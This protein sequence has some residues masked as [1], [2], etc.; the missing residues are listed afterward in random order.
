MSSRSI[1]R[2]TVTALLFLVVL[3]SSGV[4]QITHA[5]TFCYT[6]TLRTIGAGIL[7]VPTF[8]A[9]L[10]GVNT[11]VCE[12]FEASGGL[13]AKQICEKE[14]GVCETPEEANRSFFQR[15]IDEIVGFILTILLN[16]PLQLLALVGTGFDIILNLTITDFS[17]TYSTHLA[18]GIETVWKGFRDVANIVMIGMF[19]FVAFAVILNIGKYGLK[20]LGVR[21]LIVAVLINF[22]LFFTKA[23]IDVS[24]ITAI[25]FRKAIPTEEIATGF[26]QQAGITTQFYASSRAELQR[27]ANR[28]DMFASAFLYTFVVGTYAAALLA[29]LLYG[30]FLLISRIVV[31]VL[32]LVLSSAA[33]AAYMLPNSSKWFSKWWDALARYSLFAPLY[34]LLLWASYNI[35]Q[36]FGGGTGVSGEATLSNLIDKEDGA[37]EAVFALT[38]VVGLLYASTKIADGLSIYGADLAKKLSIGAL[39]AGLLVPGGL[40]LGG[41]ALVTKGLKTAAGAASTS[42]ALPLG[43]RAPLKNYSEKSPYFSDTKLGKNLSKAGVPLPSN[44]DKAKVALQLKD[45]EKAVEKNLATEVAHT[46]EQSAAESKAAAEKLKESAQGIAAATV[47][48][49][50]NENVRRAGGTAAAK[51]D[52]QARKQLAENEKEAAE[53]RRAAE[54][55]KLENERDELQRARDG[56]GGEDTQAV[57]QAQQ[58]VNARSA[59]IGELSKEINQ[60]TSVIHQMEDRDTFL[61][62]TQDMD[63]STKDAAAAARQRNLREQTRNAASAAKAQEKEETKI[64]NQIASG[65]VPKTVS[66]ARKKEL[67]KEWLKNKGGRISEIA[68]GKLSSADKGDIDGIQEKLGELSRKLDKDS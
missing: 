29:V 57:L 27:R 42:R 2:N 63:T 31:F 10:A 26:M 37:W 39:S 4:P 45:S 28:S 13:D 15:T 62:A 7:A 22:S 19:V 52:A 16:I 24:N 55:E 18:S 1:K 5:E 11:A 50:E 44:T 66:D 65:S 48:E 56:S 30:M 64:R 51:A 40:A 8:G 6:S 12:N 46:M 38:L 60:R 23:V 49:R 67:Q 47:A 54:E 53:T 68:K 25:Q 33:F 59:F 21:I 14:N 41:R 58:R 34:M 36:G 61:D 35:I 17:E 43:L 32:L 3:I 9:S 20:E